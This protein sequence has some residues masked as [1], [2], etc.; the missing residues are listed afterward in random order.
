MGLKNGGDDFAP[1]K[2][3]MGT[4]N[5]FNSKVFGGQEFSSRPKPTKK[6]HAETSV[7]VDTNGYKTEDFKIQAIYTKVRINMN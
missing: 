3:P 1:A 2:E 7:E 5:L 6:S 4:V